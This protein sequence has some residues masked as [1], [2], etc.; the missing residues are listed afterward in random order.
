M[1]LV[2]AR[3]R[4]PQGSL[5]CT[6]MSLEAR[7]RRAS[8]STS[9]HW[10]RGNSPSATP[11]STSPHSLAAVANLCSGAMRCSSA[12]CTPKPN[13]TVTVSLQPYTCCQG[14]SK[15]TCM[16]RSHSIVV[17]IP[18]SDV[19]MRAVYLRFCRATFSI[20]LV[21][22]LTCTTCFSVTDIQSTRKT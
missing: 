10:C 5:N 21:S 2:M 11:P 13:V 1:F 18:F 3:K 12:L 19:T 8:P 14:L 4:F 17:L 22:K 15:L 6:L 9:S 16:C 7:Q 20:Q